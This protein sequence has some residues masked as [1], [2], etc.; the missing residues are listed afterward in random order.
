MAAAVAGCAPAELPPDVSLDSGFLVNL[1]A[2]SFHGY[3]ASLNLPAGE[4]PWGVP[5]RRWTSSAPCE[6]VTAATPT[7]SVTASG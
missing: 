3:F 5:S 2:R 4:D 7:D 6:F 1:T